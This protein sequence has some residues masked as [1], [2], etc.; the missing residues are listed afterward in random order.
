MVN[1]NPSP[2]LLYTQKVLVDVGTLEKV[3]SSRSVS[4]EKERRLLRDVVNVSSSVTGHHQHDN[5]QKKDIRKLL[6]TLI[7]LVL[8]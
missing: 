6:H 3:V 7:L 8:I 1:R 2:D 5:R 4:V